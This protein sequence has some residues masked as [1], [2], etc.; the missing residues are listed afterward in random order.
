MELNRDTF[1]VSRSR[2]YCILRPVFVGGLA[3][4]TVLYFMPWY[5]PTGDV[6]R[7][8]LATGGVERHLSSFDLCRL[9]VSSG[10]VQSGTFYMLL[11]AFEVALTLLAVWR[12]QRWVF[13][14]G[15][16]EQL[17]TLTAFLWRSTANDLPQPLFSVFLY[18][19]S[20]GMC[21]TGFL[22]RPPM[23][24]TAVARVEESALP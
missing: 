3:L 23:K 21:F 5:T 24:R 18:Y 12:P 2:A 20:W 10:D 15:A 7:A 17:Y 8:W 22:V 16:C 9:L 14:V 19:A 13:V 1:G 4:S 11:S 6:L